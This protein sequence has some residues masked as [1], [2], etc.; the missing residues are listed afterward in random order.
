MRARVAREPITL[1]LV[2]ASAVIHATWNL[3]TKQLGPVRGAPLIW[4]LTTVS[5][6]AYAPFALVA[7]AAGGTR[8]DGTALLL[9]V[10]SGALHVI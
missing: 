4:I 7:I 3:W 8:W 2:L 1:G 10:G 6:L 5:A 9:I